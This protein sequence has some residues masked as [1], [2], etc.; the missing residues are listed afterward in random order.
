MDDDAFRENNDELLLA[1]VCTLCVQQIS[2]LPQFEEKKSQV[3]NLNHRDARATLDII[4]L[5]IY[6]YYFKI[7]TRGKAFSRNSSKFA[8]YR[9]L[10]VLTRGL[11]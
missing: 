3:Q 8:I 7:C 1:C 9:I 2:S 11:K 4:S 5:T 10:G 6:V